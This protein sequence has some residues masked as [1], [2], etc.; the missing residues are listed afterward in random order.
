ME[1]RFIV[2]NTDGKFTSPQSALSHVKIIDRKDGS[3]KDFR[4]VTSGDEPEN[5]MFFEP[6]PVDNPVPIFFVREID[7]LIDGNNKS[8][9]IGLTGDAVVS[10]ENIKSI[11]F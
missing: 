11:G 4:Q 1:N 8:Y 10:A 5:E 6:H 2:S 9:V 3:V 7:E